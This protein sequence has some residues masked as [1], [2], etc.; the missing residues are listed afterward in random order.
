VVTGARGYDPRVIRTP[1]AVLHLDGRAIAPLEV[2][3][4]R[5]ARSRGLL[6]RDGIEGALW[7]PRTSSVHTFGMRF[8]IDVARLGRDGTVADLVT[9]PP[10]ALRWWRWSITDVVEAEAGQ[11][12][13][14]GVVLGGRLTAR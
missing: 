1:P 9:L 5:R 14:W 4:T 3:T 6:A 11:L 2:A 8:A 7:L 13:A 12:A 10:G